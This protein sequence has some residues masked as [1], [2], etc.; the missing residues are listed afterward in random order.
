MSQTIQPRITACIVTH[1]SNLQKL[2]QAVGSIAPQVS[3]LIIVDAGSGADYL[4]LI[5]KEIS[6]IQIISMPLNQ[7]FGTGH[8]Y[9]FAELEKSGRAD[10]FICVNP[11]IEASDK[12]ISIMHNYMHNNPHI[13]LLVPAITNPDGS[14]QPQNKRLPNVLDLVIRRLAPK[15]LQNAA[16]VSCASIRAITPM[17]AIMIFMAKRLYLYSMMDYDYNKPMQPDF[18]SGCFMMFRADIFRRI[19]GFDQ[20]FFLYFEDADISRR[21]KQLARVEYIPHTSIMH[22]WQR[23]GHHSIKLTIIMIISAYKYFRKWGVKWR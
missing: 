18:A 4:A 22:H 14:L 19:N 2:Q 21:V 15:K 13:G 23:G 10:Y 16:L 20:R 11:D 12:A 8:N 6:G 1:R 9:G 3:E 7:G 17:L 5:Q